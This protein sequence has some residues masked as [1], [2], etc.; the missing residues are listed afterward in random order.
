MRQT[1]FLG[2]MTD[3]TLSWKQCTD[4]IIK[5]ISIACFVLRNIKYTLPLST[6]KLIYFSHI[7]SIISYGIIFGCFL[8]V[9][10]VFIMQKKV[11]GIITN[12]RS[13]DS[14]REIF[15]NCK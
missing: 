3:G 7:H 12:A 9:N 6:Q 10:E 11:I 13:R 4:Q 1:K 8:H 5:K 14:C 15:K 2:L